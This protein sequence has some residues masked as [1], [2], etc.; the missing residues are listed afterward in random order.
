[1][2]RADKTRQVDRTYGDTRL[3]DA[4][5]F[6][7]QADISLQMVDGPRRG[8]TA[9]SSAALAG[10]A[11]SDAICALAL[12]LVSGGAHDQAVRLLARVNGSTRAVRDLSKLLSIKTAA[13]YGA[14]SLSE[15]QAVEAIARAQRLIAFAD[16]QR[17]G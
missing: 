9:V 5:A 2:V 11:A 17:R 13:Q 10:V 3:S 6:L 12:G 7:Q 1:M 8:A 4:R 14:K 15:R 16:S